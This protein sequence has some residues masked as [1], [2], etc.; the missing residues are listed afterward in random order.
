M[1]V[2]LPGSWSQIPIGKFPHIYDILKDD[3]I[4]PVDKEIR[5][6]SEITGLHVATIENIAL[7]DLRKLID[8][9]RFIFSLEM[10]K[11]LHKFKQA[12][13]T[14]KLNYDVTK[15]TGGEFITL[16][17][18]N[19]T[20]DSTIQNLPEIAAIFCKPYKRKWF[21]KLVPANL[22]DNEKA[23]IIGTASVGVIYPM[24]VFFCKVLKDLYPAI[25]DYLKDRRMEI[26][27]KIES[28][29]KHNMKSTLTTGDGSLLSTT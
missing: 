12:G 1:K 26:L 18:L 19:E 21:G 24:C 20:E 6:I 17:K 22:T 25:L 4:E 2:K 5:V 23:E 9:I 28:E 14:W 13:Y 7:D 3:G 11:P 15:I 8:K 27:T 10:P 29:I 16:T